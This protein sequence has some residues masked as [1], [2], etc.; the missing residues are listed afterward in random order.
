MLPP[1][2]ELWG[3]LWAPWYPRD[4]FP[5]S[6]GRHYQFQA[7]PGAGPHGPFLAGGACPVPMC[8]G[9][10]VR[11]R[12]WLP[13]LSLTAVGASWAPCVPLRMRRPG[14]CCLSPAAPAVAGSGDDGL[15]FRVVKPSYRSLP[16]LP[17][18]GPCEA[19][20]RR[21]P[22]VAL[23]SRPWREPVSHGRTLLSR[24]E[25]DGSNFPA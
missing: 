1:G 3:P 23:R 20:G 24:P 5:L 4:Q 21:G 12:R 15:L 9:V 17:C 13:D 8:I 16:L 7:P 18:R 19:R 6:R 25:S 14:G 10:S 22:G 11:G 2:R